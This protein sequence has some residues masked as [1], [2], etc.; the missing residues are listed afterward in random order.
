MLQSSLTWSS[1]RSNHCM[2]EKIIIIIT[3]ME[4]LDQQ[5]EKA[6]GMRMPLLNSSL[7]FLYQILQR[8]TQKSHVMCRGWFPGRRAGEKLS[9]PV[10]G[11]PEDCSCSHISHPFGHHQVWHLPQQQVLLTASSPHPQN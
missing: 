7:A 2:N 4:I 1:L 10:L 6:K 11:L 5:A 8:H 9:L 3:I